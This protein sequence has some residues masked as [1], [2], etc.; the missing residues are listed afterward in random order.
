V[1]VISSRKK[2]AEIQECVFLY[3]DGTAKQENVKTGIQDNTYIQI[4]SD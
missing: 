1:E 4:L 3:T 2:T